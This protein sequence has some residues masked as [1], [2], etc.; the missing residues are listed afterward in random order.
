MAGFFYGQEL[1]QL[2]YPPPPMFTTSMY[3]SGI[4]Y[5]QHAYY[6]VFDVVVKLRSA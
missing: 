1:I 3:N 6:V 4:L 5:E 2:K